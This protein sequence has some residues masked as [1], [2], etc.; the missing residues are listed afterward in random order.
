MK[1]AT[2]YSDLKMKSKVDIT[3][4]RGLRAE[5]RSNRF[6]TSHGMPLQELVQLVYV[7]EARH[8]ACLC[9]RSSGRGFPES[10]VFDCQIQR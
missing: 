1:E 7:G 6:S 2:I 4:H 10:Q 8:P 9:I 3:Q 5:G